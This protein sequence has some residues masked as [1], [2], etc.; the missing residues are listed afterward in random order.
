MAVPFRKT[1][2]TRKR[3]RRT[4]YKLEANGMVKCPNCNALIRPHRVCGECGY[5]KGEHSIVEYRKYKMS[6]ILYIDIY[7]ISIYTTS[8]KKGKQMYPSHL[9]AYCFRSRPII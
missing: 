2:K 1:S 4:H 9:I 5:Y 8:S 3:M 7:I 6:N